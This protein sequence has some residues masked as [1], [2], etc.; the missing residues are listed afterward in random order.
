MSTRS[1]AFARWLNSLPATRFVYQVKAGSIF[2]NILVCDDPE[3]AKAEAE[4]NI[5][6]L[7][8]KEKEMKKK[9]DDEEVCALRRA[10]T[11]LPA[12]SSSSSPCSSVDASG[13]IPNKDKVRAHTMLTCVLSLDRRSSA[14]RK[15]KS[16]RPR[17]RST[18]TMMMTMTMTMTMTKTKTRRRRNCKGH[19]NETARGFSTGFF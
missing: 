18:M 6:P 7:M 8:T 14:A 1:T 12:C 10:P 4:K 17:R 15:K 5:V 19:G 2:D 13:S 16:A 9:K 11:R 3:F